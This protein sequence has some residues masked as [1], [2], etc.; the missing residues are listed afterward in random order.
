MVEILPTKQDMAVAA[1]RHA[2]N[3]LR[4]LLDGQDI[5]RLLAATGASQI[6]FLDRLTAARAID[7][8]RVEL[9][10]LDEYAGLGIDHPASFARYIQQRIVDR[11]GIVH[12]HLL[13]GTRPP[14]QVLT[15]INREIAAARVDLAFV[16]IGEN[17][18][19][20][21]NDPPA[22]FETEEPYLVVTLDPACRA[23]QVSEGWFRSLDE[24]P[25]QALS[26]SI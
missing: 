2:A 20:A 7:W 12:H 21:F 4:K 8:P 6:E 9:F 17:G 19:L 14:S 16:G 11:T 10:H 23:Q 13:D 3:S 5:V 25:R 18:H 24:V 1:S 15:A 26:I 22:D